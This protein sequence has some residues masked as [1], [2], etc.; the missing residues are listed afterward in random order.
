MSTH[1]PVELSAVPTELLQLVHEL[2]VKKS[3]G[4]QY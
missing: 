3:V 4:L 1:S 2:G